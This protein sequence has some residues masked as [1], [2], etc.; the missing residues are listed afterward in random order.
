LSS[1]LVMLCTGWVA[2]H[3]SF[4]PVFVAAG[5]MGPVAAVAL[6]LLVGRL[7]QM[8]MEVPAEAPSPD[9]KVARA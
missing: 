9:G 3:F 5:L 7:P 2:Q 6:L 1:L 8:P 4:T